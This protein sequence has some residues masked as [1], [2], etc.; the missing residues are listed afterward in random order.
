M[1]SGSVIEKYFFDHYE[2]FSGVDIGVFEI[3]DVFI[4]SMLCYFCYHSKIE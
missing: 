2:S 4:E 3:S 1:I